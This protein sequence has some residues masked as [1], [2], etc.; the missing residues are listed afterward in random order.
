[1]LTD[2]PGVR[3][4]HWT[5]DVAETGC[6]VVVLPPNTV[7][8]GEIRGGAPAT[9]EFALLDPLHL[10]LHVDAVVLSGGSAFGL[11]AGSGVVDVLEEQARGFHT[12]AG[13]VP[14]VV[15]MSLYDL[16]VGDAAVRP[17]A[18]QGRIAAEAA[19]AGPHPCGRVGAGRGATIGKW[20][21]PETTEPGGIA[22]ATIRSGEVI[23][24][25]LIA[26]NAVGW[27]DDGT[28]ITDPGPRWSPEAAT[29]G[30]EAFG[31][32]TIGVV[33]TNAILDKASCH[34]AA[35]SGHDGYAR[36]LQPAHTSADGD[37]LVVAATGEVEADLAHIRVLI[38]HAVVIAIRGLHD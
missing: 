33:V 24:S 37:A 15:G 11:A 30:S 34:L 29:P 38:Q 16:A 36:A 5:D 21:G 31:N 6:T 13:R 20:G 25:A 3:V 10:V 12:N 9:R 27:V 4:G 17:Q 1:M 35:R 7:A 32:T 19:A 8:S 28:T 26:V 18:E 14:I 2:V 23:V 22:T